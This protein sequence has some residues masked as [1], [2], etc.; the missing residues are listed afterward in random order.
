MNIDLNN[1][2]PVAIQIH[3]AHFIWDNKILIK[4]VLRGGLINDF[5]HKFGWYI[6][7]VL[8]IM[9]YLVNDTILKLL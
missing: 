4:Y 9:M 8:M 5:I 3:A 2:K 7:L 1:C 6:N